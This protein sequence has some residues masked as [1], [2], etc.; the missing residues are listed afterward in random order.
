M[1]PTRRLLTLPFSEVEPKPT[2]LCSA[3]RSGLYVTEGDGPAKCDDCGAIYVRN[4]ATNEW[5]RLSR[6]YG[7]TSLKRPRRPTRRQTERWL[8]R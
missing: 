1:K 8:H 6:V 7:G 3:C 5:Q 2:A 4:R